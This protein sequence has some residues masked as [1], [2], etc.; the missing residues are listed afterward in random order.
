[1]SKGFWSTLFAP[2]R[3][4]FSLDEMRHLHG[5]LLRNQVVT[6][7]NR[8]TV[9]E[10]LRSIAEL[11]IWSDQNDPAMVEYF[12]TENLLGHFHQILLQRANR[13]GHVAVQ[14]LQVSNVVWKA[15][16]TIS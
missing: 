14:V 1:M 16:P 15:V 10:A 7:S 5:V 11:V 12:L 4:R 8:A 2:P 3:E 6:D 13:Q 9:V